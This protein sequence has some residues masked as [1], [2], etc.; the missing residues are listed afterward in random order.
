MSRQALGLASSK[1]IDLTKRNDKSCEIR[2]FE[3]LERFAQV[4]AK[5][6]EQEELYVS[7]SIDNNDFCDIAR[8]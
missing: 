4:K 7:P 2:S 3:G 8:G 6:T 5:V 1:R